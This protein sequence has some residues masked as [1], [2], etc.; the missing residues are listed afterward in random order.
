MSCKILEHIIHSNINNHLCKD[1]ILTDKQHG[2]RK[3]RS[4]ERQYFTTINEMAKT[5]NH[6]EQTDV[7]LLDFSK[8][9]D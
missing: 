4:C 5:L 8:T 7:T 9:F 2:F 6:S 1:N 3:S